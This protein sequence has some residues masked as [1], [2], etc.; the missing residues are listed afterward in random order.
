MRGPEIYR[1]EHRRP[2]TQKS[3]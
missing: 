3:D 1:P 2:F